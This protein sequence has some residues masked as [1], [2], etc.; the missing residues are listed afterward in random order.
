[1]IPQNYYYS[2]STIRANLDRA[3]KAVGSSI[4]C[5]CSDPGIAGTAFTR[6]RKMGCEDL[7]YYLI[8]L[9]EKSL[10]SD[11]MERFKSVEEMPYP[12]AVCMQRKKL[13]PLA[14]RRVFHLF[15]GSFEN[16]KTYKGYCLL[17]CDGSDVNVCHN[18]KDK[19]TYCIGTSAKKGFNQLHINALYDV[20][21]SIYRDVSI[22]T[23]S[24]TGECKALEGMLRNGQFPQKSII[25]CDRGYEKY[26]LI[27]TFMECGRKFIIRVKDICSNGILSTLGL[28]DG[29]FDRWVT[30]TVTR[31]NNKET[32]GNGK[33]AVLMNNAPFDY[34]DFENEY[35]EMKLRVVRFKI[36]EDTYECL[37]TNLTEEEMGT[38]EF[39]EI[40][41]LRW[42]EEIAF[43]DLKYT[44]GMLYF[45]SS[46]QDMIRQE[47]YGSLI[48]YN[49][50]QLIAG[51]IPP[52]HDEKWKWK[53]KASF[54]AAVTNVRMYM[55][56]SIDE[57][58]LVLR[59][60]KFLVPIRPGRSYRRNV[61]PQS[62]KT[63]Q[64]YA[65]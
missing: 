16:Y 47:I 60:K 49:Y 58:E 17:A 63:P 15:T 21:N 4:A 19:E 52:R 53:Y 7:M 29:E 23:A 50:C 36:T 37:I 22:D 46:N 57:E 55:R 35:Y 61:R 34:I 59:I 5:Y 41:H 54:K 43:R 25:I 3:I 48:L 14:M 64:Y 26:N 38:E 51:N 10:G 20:L 13:D 9:S 33:Y 45:H 62:A 8:Q 31:V 11:L 32:A 39:R 65:A 40:Y 42:R 2:A 56:G 44:I 6:K 1:M 28:P 12:S 27:A 30:K 18:P 24:K